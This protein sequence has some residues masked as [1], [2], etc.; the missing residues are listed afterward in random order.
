[1]QELISKYGKEC[2]RI[3]FMEMQVSKVQYLFF[4]N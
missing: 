2:K 1:M 4:E 3:G